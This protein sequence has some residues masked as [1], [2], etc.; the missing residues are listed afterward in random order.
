LIFENL[1]V[2]Y[3]TIRHVW[4]KTITFK[5]KSWVDRRTREKSF[6]IRTMS[7]YEFM[8]RMLFFLPDKHRKMIRYYGIYTHGIKGKLA[9]IDRRTWAKAIEYSFKKNPEI[10][11]DCLALMIKDTVYYFLA[12]TEIKKLVKTHGIRNGYFRPYRRQRK[13]L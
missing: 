6:K 10:C 13:P 1:Y 11:P 2:P 4:K 5:Y 8:A 9:E 3:K 7:I 12:D